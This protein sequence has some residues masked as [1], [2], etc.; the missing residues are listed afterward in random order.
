MI[1][2]I[3]IALAL[4]V[5]C[6]ALTAQAAKK[7]EFVEFKDADIRDA[8]HILATLGSANIAVTQAA[9]SQKV[10][11]MLQNTT[12]K[13]AVDML[14]R[15]TGL[16][17]RYNK[18]NNSYLIMTEEQYQGDIVIY[19]DD[20]IRTFTLRHQNVNT[21]AQTIKALFGSRVQLALQEGNDDFEGLPFDSAD[22]AT[23]VKDQKDGTEAFK[24][25][26]SSSNSTSDKVT[27][28]GTLDEEEL[29]TGEIRQLGNNESIDSEKASKVLGSE[30]PIYIATNRL[31]NLMFVRTSDENALSEIAKIV[32]ESD[33][34]TPQVLLEM[35]IVKISLGETYDQS[36][37]FSFNDALNVSGL[38]SSTTATD[39]ILAAAIDTSSGVATNTM[40]QRLSQLSGDDVTRFGFNGTTGGFYDFF[41]QYVNAKINILE[42]NNQAKVIAKP[43]ILAS[44][45]RAAKLF[46]GQEQII[47]TGLESSTSFSGADSNNDRTAVTTFTLET[48]RRKVG[49]TLVLLP[50]INADRTV[51]IDILQDSSVVKRGGLRFPFFDNN[52]QTITSVN[53]DA[54]EEVN[55]KTVVVAKDG[56]T[57]ALGGMIDEKEEQQQSQVPVLGNIPLIGKLFSNESTE[58]SNS[59]YII[60]ITPH[61]LMSPEE[62]AAK[63]REISEF[64]YDNFAEPVSAQIAEKSTPQP[65]V[66]NSL[67]DYAALMRFAANSANKRAPAALAGLT[68]EPILLEPVSSIF[69]QAGIT[70][71]PLNSWQRR[72]LFVTA[73]RVSNHSDRNTPLQIPSLKG[74]WL[75]AAAEHNQLAPDGSTWLYLLSSNPFSATIAE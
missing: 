4:A 65:A 32:E 13:H 64:Q 22:D 44:N 11:L 61:I 74:N 75:A 57:I 72:G 26:T 62:S 58:D 48:E 37:D 3:K 55:I 56:K 28:A 36:V 49:N 68:T 30:T 23:V 17:Y 6:M 59:Q 69:S 19:R 46:M 40:L 16:W 12:L 24:A 67:T 9:G 33:R 35:K 39:G 43:I 47:A 10:D 60:L 21:T 50:S 45:N 20:A 38:N 2:K 51:T 25:V 73:L 31:H 5:C 18:T 63:S 66:T 27:E 8:T 34:P 52:A 29:S 53:L 70:A 15:V 14:A 1:R 42:R 41:S 54:V 7:I 71:V